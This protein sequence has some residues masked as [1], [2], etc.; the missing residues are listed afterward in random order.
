MSAED[1]VAIQNLKARYCVAVD[2]LTADTASAAETFRSIFHQRAVAE[3]GG[4]PVIGIAAL[5][6]FLCSAIAGNSEWRVHMIHTPLIVVDGD[7]ATGDWTLLVHLKRPGGTV[8]VLLGRY[9]DEFVR[10][11][12]GWRIARV[13]FLRQG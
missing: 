8:D 13:R 11:A 1:V 2:A 5:T 10:T 6:E 4:D 9:S 3:Y 12:E 7:R